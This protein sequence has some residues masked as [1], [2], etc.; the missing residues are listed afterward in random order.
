M[1]NGEPDWKDA[2]AQRLYAQAAL[3]AAREAEAREL[4]A[5]ESAAVGEIGVD[6]LAGGPVLLQSGRM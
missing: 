4:D 2:L 6:R 3:D 5:I 1:V